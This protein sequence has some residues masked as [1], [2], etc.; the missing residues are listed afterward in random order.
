MNQKRKNKSPLHNPR[1]TRSKGSEMAC[2]IC[3]KTDNS[4]DDPFINCSNCNLNHHLECAGVSLSFFSY[5]IEVKKA[6]WYCFICDCAL[7]NQS[8]STVK[9]LEKIEQL[10][11]NVNKEV[12]FLHEEI[13][14][15]KSA[16]SAWKQQF[17]IETNDRI[18]K[19][20]ENKLN[21]ALAVRTATQIT[22][23]STNP[24]RK[25]LI[26]SGVPICAEEDVVSIINKIAQRID[27]KTENF[28]DNCYRIEKNADR[29]GSN[30]QKSSPIILLKFVTELARDEFLKCYFKHIKKKKLIQ[31]SIGFN[32]N[33]R[34][35]V[36]EQLKPELQPVFKAA[37]ALRKEGKLLQVASH[38]SN[39]S[40]K[41]NRGW[42]RF[43]NTEDLQDFVK[44][45]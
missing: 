28:I 17:E 23:K 33:E 13:I 5:F 1:V 32:G 24:L 22:D 3:K 41:T 34:V 35:F 7:R 19:K 2:R 8:E 43:T 29:E 16:E 27:F 10:A 9:N 36:N 14:K 30:R 18:D 15:I 42:F 6:P 45:T 40:V 25:N 20:I 26:I 11:S 44:E 31:S 37:M 4:E 39:I 12:Q 21:E 38:S